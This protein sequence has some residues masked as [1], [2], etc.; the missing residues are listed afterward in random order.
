MTIARPPNASVH[1]GTGT[2]ELIELDCQ[3]KYIVARGPT[4]LA[5]SLEPWANDCVDAVR[6]WRNE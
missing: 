1:M 5:T 3:T 6:T 4:A 2:V